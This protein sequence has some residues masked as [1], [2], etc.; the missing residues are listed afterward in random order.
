MSDDPGMLGVISIDGPPWFDEHTGLEFDPLK[1]EQAMNKEMNSSKK[2]EVKADVPI[3]QVEDMEGELI[4]S[5]WLLNDRH[6]VKGIKARLVAQQVSDGSPQDTF[7]A[8]PSSLGQRL[9]P[10]HAVTHDWPVAL[11]DISTAFLA[12]G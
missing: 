5:G 11:G 2:F 10:Q 3:K 4:P 7:A 1:V 12:S 6:G 9:L 8:A